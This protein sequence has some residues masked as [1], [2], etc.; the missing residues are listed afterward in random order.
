MTKANIDNTDKVI[1]EQ[2]LKEYEQVSQKHIACAYNLISEN[3]AL[4]D[5][6]ITL[7]GIIDGFNSILLDKNDFEEKDFIESEKICENVLG[8]IEK[9]EDKIKT[10]MFVSKLCS[11]LLLK[12]SI[13]SSMEEAK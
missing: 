2:I 5:E 10:M 6:N 9:E 12:I 1:E 13:A 11:E 8:L 3:S 7:V 4:K